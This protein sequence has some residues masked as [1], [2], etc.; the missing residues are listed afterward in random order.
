[1]RPLTGAISGPALS[2]P[3]TTASSNSTAVL[4]ACFLCI[5]FDLAFY[6]AIR[7]AI[8]HHADVSESNLAY[9]SRPKCNVRICILRIGSRTRDRLSSIW[10]NSH[11]RPLVARHFS[12]PSVGTL[13][14]S[15]RPSETGTRNPYWG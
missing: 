6:L 8:L 7:N 10:L 12:L 13:R 2:H 15:W 11:F 1:M 14:C 9:T 5:L 3:D 4:V